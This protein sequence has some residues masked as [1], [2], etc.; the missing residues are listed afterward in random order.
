MDGVD[1]RGMQVKLGYKR[2]DSLVGW[3]PSADVLQARHFAKPP[4]IPR[5]TLPLS[6]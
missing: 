6:D 3:R 1:F 4:N 5:P 2:G